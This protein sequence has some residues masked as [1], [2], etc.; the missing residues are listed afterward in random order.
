MSVAGSEN[1][2]AADI[3]VPKVKKVLLTHINHRLTHISPRLGVKPRFWGKS[4][5]VHNFLGQ[6]YGSIW[7]SGEYMR[8]QTGGTS[9]PIKL[10]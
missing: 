8:Q 3:S 4:Q 6:V 2:V 5:V 10:N 9:I 7:I 1:V